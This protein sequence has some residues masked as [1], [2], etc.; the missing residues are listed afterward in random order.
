[1][2]KFVC[3]AAKIGFSS[4]VWNLSIAVCR[5]KH[6]YFRHMFMALPSVGIQH[7]HSQACHLYSDQ[8]KL[9]VDVDRTE[10]CSNPS[11]SNSEKDLALEI[12][13]DA[14]KVDK[15]AQ[16]LQLHTVQR[17]IKSLLAA[18]L[19]ETEVRSVLSSNSR[20]LR[21][22]KL[23]DFVLFLNGYGFGNS[24]IVA[25]LENG[26]G[27]VIVSGR[28]KIENMYNTL[29]SAGQNNA[30]VISLLANNPQ[31]LSLSSKQVLSR[32][33]A[34]KELFKT[35]DVFTLILKSPSVLLDDWNS[36]HET[37]KYVFHVMKITQPQMVKSHVFHHPLAHI[38]SR[39]LFLARSGQW[40]TGKLKQGEKSPNPRLVEIVDSTDEHFAKKF[41][42]MSGRDYRTFCRLLAKED[43]ELEE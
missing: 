32:L 26:D 42:G 39:H 27:S 15:M 10:D 40:F 6:L 31:I 24:D 21:E 37:F 3:S 30:Q 35:Q 29:L 2:S 17:Q 13:K 19:S 34:L 38:R 36:F 41:G 12:I 23:S 28:K 20:L 18:G 4:N 33:N 43:D 1:M 11:L 8:H 25:L 7:L 5:Q 14:S 9:F 16:C 22:S